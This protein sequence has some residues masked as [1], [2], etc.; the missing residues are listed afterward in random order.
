MKVLTKI[1]VQGW[2]C[3]HGGGVGGDT[4]LRCVCV[5]VRHNQ[6]C[7]LENKRTCQVDI[8]CHLNRCVFA[9]KDKEEK[10]ESGATRADFHGGKESGGKL[11][12]CMCVWFHGRA[13]P[14]Y[15]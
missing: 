7:V 13:A 12:V 9:S 4:E 6:V 1:E 14:L 10:S 5:C 3:V 11:C 15:L 8:L 2:L